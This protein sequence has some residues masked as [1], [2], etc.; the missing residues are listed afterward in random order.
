M[1]QPIAERIA[2][3]AAPANVCKL[4][5]CRAPPRPPSSLPQPAAGCVAPTPRS[6]PSPRERFAVHAGPH[7]RVHARIAASRRQQANHL[8]DARAGPSTRRVPAG[9]ATTRGRA[10]PRF[11]GRAGVRPRHRGSVN[12]HQRAAMSRLTSDGVVRVSSDVAICIRVTSMLPVASVAI[13]ASDPLSRTRRF[14]CSALPASPRQVRSPG[15]A[16]DGS[17][18]PRSAAT[19]G[20]IAER[21]SIPL[22]RRAGAPSRLRVA[23]CRS[24]AMLRHP[25]PAADPARP[26]GGAQ[27]PQRPGPPPERAGEQATGNAGKP[28]AMPAGMR[29]TRG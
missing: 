23:R 29:E 8:G 6:G 9:T 21:G 26:P 13:V 12:R 4:A 19:L 1:H 22:P 11:A 10:K 28:A 17:R 7:G 15:P 3:D 25:S 5:D 20:A 14:R 16:S 24:G 18:S 2:I 27:P